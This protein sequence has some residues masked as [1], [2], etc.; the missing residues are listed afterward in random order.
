MEKRLKQIYENFVK[1]GA[2]TEVNLPAT[3][4]QE[5]EKYVEMGNFHQTMY[6]KAQGNIFKLMEEDSFQRYLKSSHYRIYNI[7][8]NHIAEYDEANKPV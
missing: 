5:I 7:I 1:T 6:D 3:T 8:R 2:T 4:K